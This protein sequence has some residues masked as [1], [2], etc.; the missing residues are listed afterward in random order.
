MRVDGI[1]DA[2]R[3]PEILLNHLLPSRTYFRSEFNVVRE[4]LT[5]ASD[6]NMIENVRDIVTQR[7]YA[8][9]NGSRTG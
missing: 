4:S 7:F 1:L 6:T 3:Y 9:I 8:G 2:E 5:L